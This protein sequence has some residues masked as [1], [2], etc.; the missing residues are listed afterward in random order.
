LWVA[1]GNVSTK[2]AVAAALGDKAMGVKYER[3]P[4]SVA[5]KKASLPNAGTRRDT[6]LSFQSVHELFPAQCESLPSKPYRGRDSALADLERYDLFGLRNR[7]PLSA[8]EAP[9]HNELSGYQSNVESNK[10][11]W[12]LHP[13]SG[14]MQETRVT[15]REKLEQLVRSAP[16]GTLI[17]V[18]GL[19]ELINTAGDDATDLA[20]GKLAA[21]PQRRSDARPTTPPARSGSGFILV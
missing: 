2:A 3:A 19:A 11:R 8:A 17:P 6:I 9:P 10:E 16:R 21:S 15:L 13:A 12:Q 18:E 5:G 4:A 20:V 1:L 7:H 14:E